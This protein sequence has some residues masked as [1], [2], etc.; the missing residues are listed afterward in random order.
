MAVTTARTPGEIQ[1]T[2]AG[3]KG[4]TRRK[5]TNWLAF[6]VLAVAAIIWLIPLAWALDTALKTEADT[7]T[8]PVTWIP[9]AGSPRSRSGRCWR[10]GTSCA[11]TS[12]ASSRPR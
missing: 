1:E 4:Q 6:G 12:T 9:R 10:P 8:V 11:G 2:T 5:A 3:G 7:T